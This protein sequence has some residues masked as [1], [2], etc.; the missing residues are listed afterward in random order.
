MRC[1]LAL[2]GAAIWLC[3]CS[4]TPPEP[5][6]DDIQA[7]RRAAMDLDARIHREVLGRLEIDPPAAVYLQYRRSVPDMTSAVG[8]EYGVELRRIG[9]H[10]RNRAN[11][12]DDWEFDRLEALSFSM[13]AGLPP[14]QL[15]YAEVLEDEAG[16]QTFRWIR[17]IVMKEDCLVCHGE[18]ISIELL[19][20]I[21]AEYPDDEA[22]GFFEHELAGAYT[23]SRPL[24]E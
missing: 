20:M 23:V 6:P 7:A 11:V 2:S 3:A 13:D 9:L 15:E 24:G 18:E 22:T 12:A 19:D 17:P 8:A 14:E 21:A 4:P 16:K 1:F 10:V 5:H